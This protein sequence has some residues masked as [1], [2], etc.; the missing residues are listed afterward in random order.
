MPARE[1]TTAS[2]DGRTR[3][4]RK[5]IDAGQR[6]RQRERRDGEGEAERLHQLVL[7]QADRLQIGNRRNDEHAGGRRDAARQRAG[8]RAKD[9]L[10]RARHDQ[11]QRGQARGGIG[12]QRHAERQAAMTAAN[13]GQQGRAQP[14]AEADA[15]IQRPQPAQQTAEMRAVQH[16]P[17]VGDQ[18]R[19]DQQRRRLGWRQH[20]GQQAHGDGGQAKAD[21]A[22]GE[23]GQDEHQAEQDQG[24]QSHGPRLAAD[25]GPTMWR[26]W[27]LTSA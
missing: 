13:A 23:A 24:R 20:D 15:E 26:I 5:G 22:L 18:G 2:N 4:G 6:S 27:I 19:Q 9:R 10:G 11:P 14:G 3:L 16:L 8:D 25:G 12:D 7:L 1:T 17:D 21:D